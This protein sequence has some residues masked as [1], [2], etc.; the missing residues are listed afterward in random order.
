MTAFDN[1]LPSLDDFRLGW[2]PDRENVYLL[3]GCGCDRVTREDID[4]LAAHPELDTISVIGLE[5]D[6][7]E[8]FISRYGR[9]FRRIRF[10]KNQLVRDWSMLA[11]LP[12]LEWL[13]WYWNQR[14]TS[15]WDMS[16]NRSLTA[17]HIAGFT[18]LHDLSGIEKAES[19]R[20][21]FVGDLIWPSMRVRSLSPLTETGI[22]CLIW[23]GKRIE[24]QDC[25]FLTQMKRLKHMLRVTKGRFQP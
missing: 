15:L 22:E 25:T 23:A 10:F 16:K 9:Q 4:R 21:L 13:Y 2:L 7:F 5:Q 18:R 19:L 14:I 17:L 3:E 8:Y 12:D 6:G 20:M 11:D 24:D 1:D